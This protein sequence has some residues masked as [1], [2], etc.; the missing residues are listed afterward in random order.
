MCGVKAS[1]GGSE[2]YVAGQYRQQRN[3]CHDPGFINLSSQPPLL[4]RSF[5]FI[6]MY[7]GLLL[8]AHY[9]LGHSLLVRYWLAILRMT[10]KKTTKKEITKTESIHLVVYCIQRFGLMPS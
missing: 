8:F 7:G 5:F 4:S 1:L 9:C 6:F 3:S 2:P 10:V